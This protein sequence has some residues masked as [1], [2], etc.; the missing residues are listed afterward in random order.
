MSLKL[1][2]G[3]RQVPLFSGSVRAVRQSEGG[4]ICNVWKCDSAQH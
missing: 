1:P 4:S 3:A 2:A